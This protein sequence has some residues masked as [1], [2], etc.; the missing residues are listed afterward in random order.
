MS[1][2]FNAFLA[3]ATSL[4]QA[5]LHAVQ[6]IGPAWKG[7]AWFI[8][9]GVGSYP[10]MITAFVAALLLLEKRRVAAEIIIISLISFAAIY[11]AKEYFDAPRPYAID[12]TVI[13]YDHE[14]SAGLPSRHAVM[15]IVVLGWII[16][17]H[18]KS[19]VLAWGSAVLIVLIGFSRIY[20]GVHYPSQ[21]LAGWL[22]GMLFLYIFYRIDNRLWAPFKKEIRKR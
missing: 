3:S 20:L 19:K 9:H 17:K 1:E 18:P 6:S 10:I 14:D 8:S 13:A 21:V 15:S 12:P 2:F 11:V 16:L 5:I 22:F 4:D 7:V